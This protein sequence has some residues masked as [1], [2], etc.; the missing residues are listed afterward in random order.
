MVG[1]LTVLIVATVAGLFGEALIP[2]RLPG[3]WGGGALA[4]LPGALLGGYGAG[5]LGWHWGPVIG[6]LAVIPTMAGAALAE[7]LFG[8][9]VTHRPPPRPRS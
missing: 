8:W 4:A 3:G 9:W 1:W 6:S 5:H 2:A 7:W